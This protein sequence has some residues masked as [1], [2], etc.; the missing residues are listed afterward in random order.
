MTVRVRPRARTKTQLDRPVIVLDDPPAPRPHRR[1]RRWLA[2]LVPAMLLV[3]AATW[4][5]AGGDS[6]TAARPAP[7]SPVV[8]PAVVTPAALTVR[9]AGPSTAVAGQRASFVVTYSD[10]SGIFSGSIEDWGD[11]G[12]GA[13]K[14]SACRASDPAAAALHG[15]YPV[16]HTWRAAGTYPVSFAVTTYTCSGGR[17]SQE[18]QNA[19]LTVVVAAR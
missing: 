4:W 11:V 17:A 12:V 19:Q 5:M 3:G 9:V 1:L 16:T 18:T 7:E 15:S 10:G 6:E 13:V 14:Q 8:A 2:I